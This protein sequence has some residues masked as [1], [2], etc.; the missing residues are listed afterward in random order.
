MPV[1][2]IKNKTIGTSDTSFII[3]EAGVNHNG[4]LDLAKKLI[5]AASDA[6]ADAVKFQTFKADRLVLANT[7]MAKYQIANTKQNVSQYDLI[8]GLE[9]TQDA[10][11]E[12][13]KHADSRNIIFLSTPFDEQSAD[14]LESMSIEAFKVSSGEIS[15]HPFLRHVA[16]K[17]KPIIL[18]TGMSTIEEVNAAVRVILETN[19]HSLAILHCVSNY[20]ADPSETNLRAIETLQNCFDFPIGFSDH[21]AGITIS[22]AARAL[23]AC[24]IEK[25][26]TLDTGLPGPDHAMSLTVE[27]LKELVT[28]IRTVEKALGTGI[29]APTQSEE[30]IKALVRRSITLSTDLNA[31]ETLNRAML[32]ALRPGT[33][34]SP[35]YLESIIGRQVNRPIKK[36]EILQWGDL[37]NEGGAD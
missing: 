30:D 17:Q 34:I 33:G 13:K 16:H 37:N 9:L 31:G 7:S 6:G 5:D 11:I 32:V 8:K 10:F 2:R 1:I 24:I 26:F 28:E 15:N 3:A 19:N 12:L 18:S 35:V 14:F 22:L 20:P 25:H 21:S 23:G 36:G 27:Q 4:R 29:K